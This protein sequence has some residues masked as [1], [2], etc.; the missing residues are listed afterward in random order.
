M[1]LVRP[2]RL[3]AL[4]LPGDTKDVLRSVGLPR[5]VEP[6]F[7]LNDDDDGWPRT[8]EYPAG[9]SLAVVGTDYGTDVCVE[10]PSGAVRAVSLEGEYP[11]RFVNSSVGAFL[12]CLVLVVKERSRFPGLSDADSDALLRSLAGC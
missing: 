3:D 7:M 10:I 11:E 6:F 12:E 4:D 2:E 9:R 8:V 5:E 1:A